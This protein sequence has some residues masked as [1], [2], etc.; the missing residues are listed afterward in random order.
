MRMAA[1]RVEV[2][3]SDPTTAASVDSV[4]ATGGVLVTRGDDARRGDA[5]TLRHR[6]R[7]C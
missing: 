2:V 5:G 1:G 3:Y 7:A 6:R 4:L